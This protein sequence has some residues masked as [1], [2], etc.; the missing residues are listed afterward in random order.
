MQAQEKLEAYG[1]RYHAI[2]APRKLV[3]QPALGMVSLSLLLG[4]QTQEFTV[5]PVQVP[6]LLF[7]GERV[8]QVHSTAASAIQSEVQ[9]PRCSPAHRPCHQGHAHLPNHR[10]CWS[11]AAIG[12]QSG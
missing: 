10:C 5:S 8:S 3:W 12:N 7:P 4:D 11:D 6:I 1:K 2:K 9:A